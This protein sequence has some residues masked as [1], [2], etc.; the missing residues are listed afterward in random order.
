MIV[1]CFD[2]EFEIPDILIDKFVK[3]FDGL[4]GSGNHDSV[5]ELR[6]SVNEV[7]DYIAEDPDALHEVE[8]LSDFIRALAIRKA[9]SVHG[10]L[11]DA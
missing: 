6:E 8:Y 11:Y 5:L 3:Q 1:E 9:L 10:I 2:S 7:L 4:A